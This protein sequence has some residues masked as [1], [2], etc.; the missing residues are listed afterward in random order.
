M[1][2]FPDFQEDRRA[3]KNLGKVRQDRLEDSINDE[4]SQLERI[5]GAGGAGGEAPRKKAGGRKRKFGGKKK[6]KKSSKKKVG[7]K[8][9][10]GRK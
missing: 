6:S 4:W 9:R 7:N 10:K 2:E 3:R 1:P 5:S 8:R